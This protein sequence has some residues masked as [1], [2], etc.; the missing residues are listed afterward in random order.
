MCFIAQI[1]ALVTTLVLASYSPVGIAHGSP[2]LAHTGHLAISLFVA[3]RTRVAASQQFDVANP[4]RVC[5]DYWVATAA[6]VGS[7]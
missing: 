1:R 4:V 3:R 5:R 7:R 2:D 6:T